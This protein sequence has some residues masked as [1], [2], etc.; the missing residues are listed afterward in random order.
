M[1]DDHDK[2]YSQIESLLEENELVSFAQVGQ[3]VKES[4]REERKK[5]KKPKVR[6]VSTQYVNKLR[7]ADDYLEEF[8]GKVRYLGPLRDEP[9]PIYPLSSTADLSDVG[10]KGECTASVLELY[11]KKSIRY[12][13]ASAFQEAEIKP[14]PKMSSLKDAVE[15]WLKY[16]DM[17]EN[18]ESSDKGK[19]G[20]GLAVRVAGNNPQSDLTHVGV[21]VSQVLPIL[22]TSL[23]AKQDTTLIFEQPELHLHPKV[24]ARLADFFL[25]VTKLGKQCILETHS[26]HLIDRIRRRI[27]GATDDVWKEAAKVYFVEQKPEGST[28]RE[29]KINK[30][31]AIEDWPEGFFDQ[32]PEESEAILRAAVKKRRADRE[33]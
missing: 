16:L 5:E 23:V 25:S 9:K 3:L 17:A 10:I 22:V 28:F 1:E 19:L 21:G 4:V 26:E 2:V 24:Q 13:P 33:K 29:V 7:K 32:G 30:Y 31:G 6:S 14:D 20:H 15:D 8:F 18:V 12:V 11:K 27:A